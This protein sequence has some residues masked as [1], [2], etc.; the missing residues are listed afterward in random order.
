MG[1]GE[2]PC[3]LTANENLPGMHKQLPGPKVPITEGGPLQL[4][5][6]ASGWFCSPQSQRSVTAGRR[7]APCLRGQA[8]CSREDRRGGAEGSPHSLFL[9]EAHV[10]PSH[11]QE[12]E[13]VQEPPR[14]GGATGRVNGVEFGVGPGLKGD[15][16]PASM[17]FEYSHAHPSG[18][19]KWEIRVPSPKCP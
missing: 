6:Q 1:P 13:Q 4:S 15:G 11:L 19:S 8:W 10:Q 16:Y 7:A 12:S 18:D 3:I 2:Q 14:G 9:Q 17:P 5:L